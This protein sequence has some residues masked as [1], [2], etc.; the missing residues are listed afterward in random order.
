MAK[1]NKV[2]NKK[3]I[4]DYVENRLW[5]LDKPSLINI[6]EKYDIPIKKSA[7][8][9]DI[10]Q[11]I[12]DTKGIDYFGI[13]TNYNHRCFALSSV[14]LEELIGIDKTIRK[15]MQKKGIL[16]V[17]YYE[18][19]KINRVKIQAPMYSLESLYKMKQEEL[20][21]YKEKFKKRE[22]TEKQLVALEKA[23][24]TAIKNRTCTKCGNIL[25][26][27]DKLKDGK[28]FY[29]I[30]IE[31]EEIHA[32]IIREDFKYFLKNK[33]KFI[34]LDTETTGLDYTDEIVEISI[35]DMDGNV[36]LDTLIYT[37]VDISPEA[38][39]VNGI[40]KEMLSGK[41]TIKDLTPKLN[42]IFKDKTVLIYNEDFDTRML[43]QSGFEGD[44]K[45][46]CLMNL[47]MQ[48]CNSERWISLSNA[49]L[50]EDVEEIQNHRA[51]GDCQ[52]CLALIKKIAED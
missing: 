1:S 17:A 32:E 40:I 37:N 30:K 6:C 19:C 28:C 5:Q 13:Y 26:S 35:I 2:I 51:L 47:Y 39:N 8:K 43:Y 52:C 29:C 42:E 27:K 16:E 20:E 31:E 41:P 45:S 48:L 25:G 12:R 44:I 38:S 4:K 34:I 23:R 14:A 36:L 46:E 21:Q 18:D 11:L 33:D 49:M 10:I 24:E 15:K 50:F 7:L 3:F 9:D 22:I